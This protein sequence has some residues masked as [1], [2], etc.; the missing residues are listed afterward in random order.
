MRTLVNYQETTKLF[1]SEWPQSMK[2]GNVWQDPSKY[3]NT[4]SEFYR[5]LNSLYTK[6]TDN[7]CWGRF[8]LDDFTVFTIFHVL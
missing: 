6:E 3:P 1:S 4:M 8:Y 5:T 7:I 2:N